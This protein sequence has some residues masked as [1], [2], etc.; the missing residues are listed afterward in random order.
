[1]YWRSVA[2]SDIV[3]LVP[4]DHPL[5]GRSDGVD[6]RELGSGPLIIN[7]PRVGYGEAVLAVF[8]GEGL[9]PEIIADCDDIE[10]LKYM[11][12]SGTGVAVVPRI[13]AQRELDQ[14]LIAAI[15]FNPR[16]SVDIHFVRRPEPLSARLE[17]SLEQLFREF[18]P[19]SAK[20]HGRQAA[21]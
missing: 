3:I 5:A 19:T 21:K 15:P 14:G 6:A 8:A 11:V 17:Q 7:E 16:R 12:L 20:R 18:E 4:S 9:S 13:V 2:Q 10:S 1:L